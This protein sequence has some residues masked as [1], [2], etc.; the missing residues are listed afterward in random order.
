MSFARLRRWAVFRDCTSAPPLR[1]S[2]RV[3]SVLRAELACFTHWV[4]LPWNGE[5]DENHLFYAAKR[6]TVLPIE[7]IHLGN[8]GY[9]NITGEL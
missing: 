7:Q 9:D 1:L 5:R 8:A 3:F 6:T 2:F 4:V